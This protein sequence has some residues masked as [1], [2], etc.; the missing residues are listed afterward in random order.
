MIKLGKHINV[1][2]ADTYGRINF[3][4]KFILKHQMKLDVYIGGESIPWDSNRCQ[5]C[6]KLMGREV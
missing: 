5:I 3:C 6:G 2:N 4:L 1:P